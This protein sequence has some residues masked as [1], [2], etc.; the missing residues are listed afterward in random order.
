MTG[1]L[2]GHMSVG[3]TVKI[4]SNEWQSN[5]STL[6]CTGN[7]SIVIIKFYESNEVD[8]YHSWLHSIMVSTLTFN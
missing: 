1:Q 3:V 4:A 8:Y 2:T 5:F 7:E 6:T